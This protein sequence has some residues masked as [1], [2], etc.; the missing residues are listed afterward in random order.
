MQSLS[1][2]KLA[3]A[4]S[5]NLLTSIVTVRMASQVNRMCEFASRLLQCIAKSIEVLKTL[6]E[7]DTV[8]VYGRRPCQQGTRVSML[9]E[10]TEWLLTESSQNILWLYG[11][12]GS[13][14]STISRSIQDYML[15][16]SRLGAYIC[17]ERGK[18]TP[19]NV[20]RTIAYQLASYD[21][22]IAEAISTTL[23]DSDIKATPLPNQFNLLLARPLVASAEHL[24]GPIIIILDALD[25]CGGPRSR[26]ELLNVMAGFTKLP[27]NFRFLITG[28]PEVDLHKTF[29]SS[30][31]SMNI[32]A[33]EL[34]CGS[35]ETKDDVLSFL[36]HELRNLSEPYEDTELLPQWHQNIAKLAE[37]S[38]G[39]FIS[40][41]TAVKMIEVSDNPFG[42]LREL[43]SGEIRIDELDTLYTTVLMNSGVQWEKE[44]SASRF[45]DIVSFMI[46]RKAPLD[47]EIIDGIM[48]LPLE[49]SARFIL[50]KVRPLIG[51]EKGK[52]L[53]FRHTTISDYF[54]ASGSKD[55]PW[56]LELTVFRYTLTDRCFISMR[57]ALKFNIGGLLSSCYRNETVDRLGH[58]PA[59]AIMPYLRYASN[60][61]AS[62]LCDCDGT[63]AMHLLKALKEF[64]HE[65]LLFWVEV[66]S[67]LRFK[68]IDKILCDASRWLNLNTVC[69]SLF[70]LTQNIF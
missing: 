50:E 47:D 1:E 15:S 11:A 12:A 43:V 29:I 27:Y 39:L 41:S 40:A 49:H 51:Y 33:V 70:L 61:W 38:S 32:R 26:K 56:S 8:D 31:W 65:H 22:H 63:K 52:P 23:G 44:A 62:H 57:N 35:N 36:H 68:G 42:T 53:Y 16:L 14:K 28:R 18:S 24:T 34:D 60:H 67:L 25:E 30:P 6:L 9:Q 21:A 10:V 59:T 55:Y 58:T 69:I 19:N 66:M 20:I 64:L 54:I 3:I 2:S 46:L 17:F 37:A 4:Q 48:G 13:G 45:R 7:P 5:V